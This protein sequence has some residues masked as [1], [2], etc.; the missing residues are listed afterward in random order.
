VIRIELK[1]FRGAWT[2]QKVA[3]RVRGK[4]TR[5]IGMG[6]TVLVDLEDAADIPD[7]FRTEVCRDWPSDK[8]KIVGQK[9]NFSG[10]NPDEH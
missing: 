2:V 7:G 9:K 5:A 3:A 6:H 8:V 1:Q 10:S 4:I